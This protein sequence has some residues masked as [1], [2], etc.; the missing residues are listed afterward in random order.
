MS[1]LAPR[2]ARGSAPLL[3]AVAVLFA[4]AP[5]SAGLLE[6]NHA[7]VEQ[8]NEAYAKGDYEGALKLYDEAERDLPRSAELHYNRGNALMKLGRSDDAR[9]SYERALT[10][11]GD[12]LKARDYYNLGNAFSALGKEQ[13]AISAWRQSLK[14]DPKFEPARH[15][16]EL[17]LLRKQKQPPPDQN[18][19][20]PGDGGTPDGGQQDAG[21]SDG[22][23]S[24]GGQDGGTDGGQ[25]GGGQ[26][27]DDG[28]QDAGTSGDG[29]ESDGGADGG[30]DGGEGQQADGGQQQQDG[31]TNTGDG[32]SG[33]DG[34][35]Q[36]SDSSE[37]Q[38]AGSGPDGGAEDAGSASAAEQ[39]EQEKPKDVD[40]QRAEQLLD[41]IRR[42]EKQFLM[43]Q[44]QQKKGKVR[45]PE[46][47]W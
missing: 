36:Q 23:Q 41:A 37:Q 33:T 45:V 26:G 25:D 5:A 38:D 27:Q 34:G 24:D 1:T 7:L 43:H 17:T 10:G 32:G 15:N 9:K 46:R 4:A 3:A 44:Q 14:V 19:Q 42:N 21:Q 16:L 29:G 40:R 11:A 30:G 6:S 47:D 18:K 13:E 35:Q 31:G 28:G 8:A 12:G 39:T 22:G 20:E 2:R